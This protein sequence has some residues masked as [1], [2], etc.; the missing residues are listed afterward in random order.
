M[1]RIAYVEMVGLGL[2]YATGAMS[3]LVGSSRFR[4]RRSR[5]GLQS[6]SRGGPLSIERPLVSL[7]L[8]SRAGRRAK[9]LVEA[10]APRLMCCCHS[11]L[12]SLGWTSLTAEQ[13]VP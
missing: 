1:I 7:V 13:M 9:T 3:V 2:L 6:R 11:S 12:P 4:L 8:L 5:A 10:L